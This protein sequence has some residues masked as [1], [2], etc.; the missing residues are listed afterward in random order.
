MKKKVQIIIK[1]EKEYI[2]N[3]SRGY[4]FNYLIPQGKAIIP[5]KKKMRQ[6]EMFQTINKEKQKIN[7][8]KIKKVR[9]RLKEINKISIYKKSGENNLIFGS[10]TEKEVSKWITKHTNLKIDKG[11]VKIPN[12]KKVG[13]ENININIKNNIDEKLQ[14]NIIPA[15]I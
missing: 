5:T 14:I 1:D 2:V 4:A 9:E 7:E 8:I 13:I 3:V 15:N 10:I 12:I 6:I 11:Q